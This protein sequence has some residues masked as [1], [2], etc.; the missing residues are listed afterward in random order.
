MVIEEACAAIVV[1]S[2]FGRLTFC[3]SLLKKEGPC[4]WS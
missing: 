2:R 4:T 1:A 3:V